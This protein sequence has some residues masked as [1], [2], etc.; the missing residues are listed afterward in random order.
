M[1]KIFTPIK[2]AFSFVEKHN[3]TIQTVIAFSMLVTLYFTCQALKISKEQLQQNEQSL[4]QARQQLDSTIEPVVDIV[5]YGENIYID[6]VGSV[7]ISHI[8]VLAHAAMVYDINEMKNKWSSFYVCP[9]D[10]QVISL[11][12]KPTDKERVFD[13]REYSVFD[14]IPECSNTEMEAHCLVIS[15]RRTVDCKRYFYPI[16]YLRGKDSNDPAQILY[17]PLFIRRGAGTIPKYLQRPNIGGNI[18][19]EFRD[20]ISEH[21][22]LPI[23]AGE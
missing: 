8:E 17:M 7:D 6:N 4:K 18:R 10:F 16:Y 23:F 3:S 11:E 1:K 14:G 22:D 2:N 20:I 13:L 19:K 15:Y 12:L 9:S 5:Q 21:I